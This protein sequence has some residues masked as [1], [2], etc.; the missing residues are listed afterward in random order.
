M[1]RRY[2]LRLEGEK[3]TSAVDELD[4]RPALSIRGAGDVTTSSMLRD[5]QR[6]RSQHWR[7]EHR[8]ARWCAS[9][10]LRRRSSSR[11]T[12]VDNADGMSAA[13]ISTDRRSSRQRRELGQAN[14]EAPARTRGIH[15][16]VV[17]R[18]FALEIELTI[19]PPD[20]GMETRDRT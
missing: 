3:D 5:H 12:R 19:D 6:Q 8:S 1:Q 11:T 4:R 18:R 16:P 17:A 15:C 2:R 13:G 14:R 7:D 9:R 10:L 20:R